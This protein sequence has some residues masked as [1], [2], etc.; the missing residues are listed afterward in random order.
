[1]KKRMNEIV[2]FFLAVIGVYGFIS[3]NALRDPL[4][5]SHAAFEIL[6]VFVLVCLT[7]IWAKTIANLKA[8]N[9]SSLRRDI[10]Y[11]LFPSLLF[12]VTMVIGV[13][14]QVNGMTD[15]GFIAKSNLIAKGICL[16]SV[17]F[18][19]VYW[20]I[21]CL[22][23]L[24]TKEPKSIQSPAWN[25]KHLFFIAWAVILIC[26][27]PV[28]L[29][30]YPSIMAY[31]FHRQVGDAVR[32][33]AFMNP[34]HPLIHSWLIW[35]ALQIG[36]LVHSNE[37]GMA[38]YTIFQ[39]IILSA[40]LAYSIQLLY[41]L[42]NKKRVSVIVLLFYAIFPYISVFAVSATKDVLF[43]AFFLLFL[44]LYVDANFFP[45][46]KRQKRLFAIAWIVCGIF[47]VMFRNNAIY[48]VCAFLVFVLIIK[49]KQSLRLCLLCLVVILGGKMGL[50]GIQFAIGTQLRGSGSEKY[51]V[52]IQQFARVGYYHEAELD[53]ETTWYLNHY[54][55]KEFWQDYDPPLADTVKGPVAQY[56]Y[57]TAW[58]GHMG[59][60]LK[61][62]WKLGLTYPNEYLDAFLML[63]S[64]YWFLDDTTFYQVYDSGED[65]WAGAL[66]T[67]STSAYDF[68]EGIAT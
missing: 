11:A 47:M 5:K 67:S 10:L 32:G 3:L 23:K 19:F 52:L 13:Q 65:H 54:V 18:P 21:T 49:R 66:T 27:V 42:S 60:V 38:F 56:S 6:S 63:T 12:G 37:I 58:H 15:S 4:T 45:R 57:P 40:V 28:F 48:A 64:G 59:E 7:L 29:A 22:H 34:H 39:M 62:W 50:E 44:L 14:L 46:T 16:S 61:F 33:F 2:A 1:M 25:V 30:F 36:N 9:A 41:R 17:V 43:G 31:D 8:A 26:W 35:V 20:V 55:P 68:F 24:M 51:S 53:G